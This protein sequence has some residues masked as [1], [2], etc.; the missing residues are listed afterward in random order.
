MDWF[1]IGIHVIHT[2]QSGKHSS[3]VME[4]T[5]HAMGINTLSFLMSNLW[6]EGMRDSVQHRQL[7]CNIG[8][9]H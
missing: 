5:D 7:R 1:V 4:F 3:Y 9:V 2:S 6:Q 8:P